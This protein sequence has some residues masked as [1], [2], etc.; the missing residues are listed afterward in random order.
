MQYIL[1]LFL[2]L[3]STNSFAYLGWENIIAGGN[4]KVGSDNVSI[5]TTNTNVGIGSISP[6]QAL[7]V[8]G[9][10][11]ATTF[12]TNHLGF[13]A[14]RASTPLGNPNT[15]ITQWTCRTYHVATD[16]ISALKIALPNYTSYTTFSEKAIGGAATV[17][18]SIEYPA[19]TLTKITFNGS[20]SGTIS[21]G[22]T[23]ISDLISP[24]TPIPVGT[25]FWIRIYWTNSAGIIYSNNGLSGNAAYEGYE[26]S[27]TDQTMNAS[28][29]PTTTFAYNVYF[30]SA[31]IGYT[32]NP[33]VLI[34]GDSR[35]EG[36]GDT[37][38]TQE[39][40][41]YERIVGKYYG[42]SNQAVPGESFSGNSV[43]D[44]GWNNHHTQRMLLAPYATHV[45]SNYGIND[46]QG[47][48]STSNIETWMTNMAG[49]FTIPVYGATME[50]ITTSTDNWATLANQ[51]FNGTGN[52]KR[53]TINTDLRNHAIP[54]L[55]GYIEIADTTES[56]RNSGKWAVSGT[57]GYYT[58]DGIHAS[59]NGNILYGN[60][61]SIPISPSG[62]LSSANIMN[63]SLN[64]NINIQGNMY[65]PSGN[66]GIGTG[67][68]SSLLE[69]GIQKFNVLSGGNV[70]VGS[71]NP[72]ATLD[73]GPTGTLRAVGLGTT[74]PQQICRKADGTFG[75][76]NGAWASVCN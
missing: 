30:P 25:P 70:G 17:T 24:S 72:G 62:N 35:A 49:L 9:T 54:K 2:L 28:W 56:S 68:P 15:G 42:Y 73:I 60:S 22:G 69:V 43:T 67:L 63:T 31:I 57:A 1:A 59:Q 8:N 20:S 47:A 23:L 13:I 33:S 53:I 39:L 50:T 29:T 19:N 21:D 41:G 4:W 34:L 51:T 11:K 71:S 76:F 40:S 7:D 48:Q 45:I 32:K 52:T 27:G 16:N 18:A 14:T 64:G 26:V 12:L 55:S 65:L 38:D 74:V 36:Q 44:A 58:T 66:L 5:N 37:M 46:I 75:Y 3:F 61:V 6:T 10:V